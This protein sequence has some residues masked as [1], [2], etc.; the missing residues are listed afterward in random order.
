MT[1]PYRREVSWEVHGDTY[2]LRLTMNDLA[3]L[4]QSPVVRQHGG[5]VGLFN[6]MVVENRYGLAEVATILLRGLTTGTPGRSWKIE[7]VYRFIDETDFVDAKD[8]AVKLLTKRLMKEQPPEGQPEGS[9]DPLALPPT[10]T[11]DV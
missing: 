7:D 6:A 11:G 3:I 9:P 1:N 8:V 2:V 10:T 5:I 4:E